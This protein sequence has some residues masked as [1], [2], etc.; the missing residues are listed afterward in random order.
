MG[1]C[2]FWS[3]KKDIV[4]CYSDC[5]MYDG[6]LDYEICPFK[7]LSLNSEEIKSKNNPYYSIGINEESYYEENYSSFK[8]K[9]KV[10]SY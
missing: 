1:K 5:P 6:K 10:K 3:T 2:P 8:T 7:E 4:I 9:E